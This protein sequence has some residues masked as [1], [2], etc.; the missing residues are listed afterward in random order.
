MK[1]RVAQELAHRVAKKWKSLPPG[2]TEDSVKKFWD[3][4]T[5]DNPEHPVTECIDRMEGK[6]KEPGA[7]CGGL[8]DEMKPGWRSMKA[9]AMVKMD[10]AT[11]TKIN[12]ALIRAGMDGN[13][14]FQSPGRG[15]AALSEVLSEFGYELESIVSGH[16]VNGPAGTL[17]LDIAQ[18]NPADSFSPSSVTNTMVMFSY[19]VLGPDRVEVVAYLS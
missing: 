19:T 1:P 10:R 16:M 13:G 7:F 9:A 6:F 18:S 5:Q 11:R 4:L 3:T 8:A 12:A 15:V 14:R 17:R 2:W